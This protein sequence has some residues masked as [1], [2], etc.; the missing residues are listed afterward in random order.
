MSIRKTDFILNL[1]NAP[2]SPLQIGAIKCATNKEI[3]N[4]GTAENSLTNDILLPLIQQRPYLNAHSLTYSASFAPEQLTNAIAELFHDYFGIEDSKGN[5]I[6]IGSG[7]AFLVEKIALVLCE[8]GDIVLI[9]SPCYG[10]FEPDMQQSRVKVVYIDLDNLPEKPPENSKLLLLTNP[11]NPYGDEIKDQDKLLKWAY[12]NPDLHIISDEV[13][14]LSNRKGKKFQSIAGRKDALP[15]RVHMFYGVSKDWGMA[16]Y[17]VGFFWSRNEELVKYLRLACGCFTLSSD[18]SAIIS[19][20]IGTKSIRDNFIKTF[21]ERLIRAYD[22]STKMFKDAGITVRE[23]DNSLFYVIDLS[24]IA[25]ESIEKELEFWEL[26]MDKYNVHILPLASG[27]HSNHPGHYRVCFSISDEKLIEGIN[28][29]CQA[30]ND[31][32]NKQK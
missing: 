3:I 24:D 28:R 21:R 31:A 32:R 20:V 18:T 25:G 16:G 1:E 22:I 17:H 5:Q 15:D 14:A 27:F 9:P 4:L 19:H 29:I 13:Y 6:V 7:I 12:Q 26:L 2:K 8:P 23:C 11:G 10:C 30:V